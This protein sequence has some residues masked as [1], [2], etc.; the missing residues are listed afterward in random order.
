[1]ASLDELVEAHG[2]YGLFRQARAAEV[3]G[4]ADWQFHKTSGRISF[5]GATIRE[6]G[7]QVLGTESVRERTWLWSWANT[8]SELPPHVLVAANRMKTLGARA[9]IGGLIDP[10]LRLEHL[11]AR[12][13]AAMCA[14]TLDA[15]AFYRCP[16]PGG[17]MY[18][19]LEDE[20]LRDEPGDALDALCE[21]IEGVVARVEGPLL[22]HLQQLCGHL[23]LHTEPGESR[24]MI[25]SGE[26]TAV[27]EFD[28]V[29]GLLAVRR[30]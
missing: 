28:E 20:S 21:R 30:S 8:A 27:V 29:G 2:L 18:V 9:G 14:V 10:D 19:L 13:L 12:G 22:P 26:S 6:I 17:A 5:V 15:P 11:D 1:M 3:L 4:A 25:R 24:L 23:A 16:Y 7:V